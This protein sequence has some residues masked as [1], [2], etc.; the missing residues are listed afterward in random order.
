[1][2]HANVSARQVTFVV[3]RVR[4]HKKGCDGRG[5]VIWIQ[6]KVYVQLPSEPVLA[7]IR[8]GS[9]LRMTQVLNSHDVRCC[10]GSG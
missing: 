3:T 6:T 7:G 4:V 1:M 8:R 5:R 2:V 9:G 10:D